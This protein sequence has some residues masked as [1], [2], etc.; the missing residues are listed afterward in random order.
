MKNF[1]FQNPMQLLIQGQ[2]W[3]MLRT[4]RLQAEQWWQRSGLKMLHIRQYRRLLFSGS[5]KWKP[6]NTGTCPGSVVIACTNDQTS[7]MKNTWK[8][9]NRTKTHGSSAQYTTVRYST[10]ESKSNSG[11]Y[12]LWSFRCLLVGWLWVPKWWTLECSRSDQSRRWQATRTCCQWS[13]PA[14]LEV[15]VACL[16]FNSSNSNLFPLMSPKQCPLD[17]NDLNQIEII[18]HFYSH[19]NN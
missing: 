11:T 8:I 7:I 15:Y 18:S 9:D 17:L 1:R 6:Q 4:Q 19:C 3:S 14:A 12:N 13:L 10:H 5:P 16:L 2:W